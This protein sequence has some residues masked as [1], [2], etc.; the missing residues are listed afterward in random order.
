MN[1]Y[2]R[3]SFL[4]YFTDLKW[5]FNR[6]AFRL[7]KFLGDIKKL[8]TQPPLTTKL[9]MLQGVGNAC[10]CVYYFTEQFVWLFK[11]GLLKN[12]AWERR[13]S[14]ISVHAEMIALISSMT[15]CTLQLGSLWEREIALQSELQRRK[16]NYCAC[17]AAIMVQE[18]PNGDTEEDM[19]AEV[20]TLRA[21]RYLRMI[22]MVQDFMDAMI[23][24]N[25]I[26]G[27]ALLTH[28]CMLRAY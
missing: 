24:A 6:K 19:E 14:R 7:G 13:A 21:K 28:A 8:R 15:V 9:G 16:K 3:P 2:H 20:E 18:D 27:E 4:L 10:N 1:E 22:D 17:N 11:T 26:R 23:A 25:D 5:V 12:D